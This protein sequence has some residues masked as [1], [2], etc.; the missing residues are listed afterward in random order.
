VVAKSDPPLEMYVHIY[1]AVI[2]GG[3]TVYIC[4][5]CLHKKRLLYNLW[6]S[7]VLDD[8]IFYILLLYKQKKDICEMI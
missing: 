6:A 7:C 1:I 3:G 5:C 4:V 2:G 8:K